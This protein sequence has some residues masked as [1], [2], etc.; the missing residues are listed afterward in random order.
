MAARL[1]VIFL[2]GSIAGWMISRRPAAA[3][4]PAALE[5]SAGAASPGRPRHPRSP[6][7]FDA[8]A[9]EL[10]ARMEPYGA[11]YKSYGAELK[12]WPLDKIRAALAQGISDPA[13][14]LPSGDAT[15]ALY[16][17]YGEFCKRDPDAAWAWLQ[18]LPSEAM[19]AYLGGALVAAWPTNRA[20]EG[21]ALVLANRDYFENSG[22]YS[23]AP[24]LP[25]ALESAASRGTAAADELLGILRR[26]GMQMPFLK[27]D[28]P[29]GFDF[30]GWTRS[31]EMAALL[32]T[33]APAFLMEPWMRRE[34]QVAMDFLFALNREQGKP[35]SRGIFDGI[36]RSTEEPAVLAGRA[37]EIAGGTGSLPP[38]EQQAVFDAAAKSLSGNT[39]FLREFSAA[40][41]DMDMRAAANLTIARST[42]AKDLPFTLEILT[43]GRSPEERAT[44]LEEV[45]A[46]R[47]TGSFLRMP[48]SEE[49]SVRQILA[50]WKLA[51]ERIDELVKAINPH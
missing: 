38:E 51:P 42:A 34:P 23:Y 17:L 35:V 11:W 49:S 27:I 46:A 50:G 18:A 15:R 22:G 31:P 32:K 44:A 30:A 21:L 33:Q 26:E 45:L 39:A 2:L 5:P 9:D 43:E 10:S 4:A 3:E 7:D 28:Y 19:R 20:E 25:R 24:L 37:R 6:Q 48:P 12:D 41:P 16:S 47:E 29:A 36:Y 1:L 14:V 40:L 13:V 8:W